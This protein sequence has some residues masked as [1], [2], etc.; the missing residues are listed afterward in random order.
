MCRRA[1][2]WPRRLP[3]PGPQPG[4]GAAHGGGPGL[5]VAGD[6]RRY[7]AR[8]NAMPVQLTAPE[9]VEQVRGYIVTGTDMRAAIAAERHDLAAVLRHRVRLCPHRLLIR[10]SDGWERAVAL[11]PKSVSP[12]LRRGDGRPAGA[13]SRPARHSWGQ[14]ATQGLFERPAVSTAPTS[15]GGPEF[16]VPIHGARRFDHRSHVGFRVGGDPADHARVAVDAHPP[17]ELELVE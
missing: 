14:G 8:V 15:P 7:P 10:S 13:R 16:G 11:E 2:P 4:G 17:P 9:P 1:S 5:A 3:R 6:L 12:V